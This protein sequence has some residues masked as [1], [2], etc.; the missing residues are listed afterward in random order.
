MSQNLPVDNFEWIKDNSQFN[1]D[2]IK[3]CYEESDQGYFLKLMFNILKN[4]MNFIMIY[5]F[6]TMNIVKLEKLVGNV[7]D[8][9]EHVIHVRNL[10]QGLNHRLFSKNLHRI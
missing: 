6:E 7:N 1:E 5:H 4:D 3:N 8:K 10:K 9:T 2:F